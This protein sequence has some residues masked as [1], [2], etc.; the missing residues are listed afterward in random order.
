MTALARR[1]ARLEH[2]LTLPTAS[3]T[4][5]DAA[6]ALVLAHGLPVLTVSPWLLDPARRLLGRSGTRLATVIGAGHGG[7]IGPVKAYEASL[8]L[9]HGARTVECV[10]NVGALLSGDD[11]TV[12]GDL[13]SVVEMAHAALAEAGVVIA[14]SPLPA[15]VVRRACRLAEQAG[16]DYIVT[17]DGDADPERAIALCALLRASAGPRLAVTASGRF[18]SADEILRAMDAGATRVSATFNDRLAAETVAALGL[19]SAG[20]SSTPA[21]VA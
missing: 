19:G 6:V 18:A 16:A 14:A 13:L 9:A 20:S 8:A 2:R 1:A 11:A 21:A 17:S 5:L 12:L 10:L 4:D 3:L 7:Q 15:E